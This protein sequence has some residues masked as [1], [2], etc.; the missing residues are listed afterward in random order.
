MG[1]VQTARTYLDQRRRFLAESYLAEN[2]HPT[3]RRFF[4]FFGIK[5]GDLIQKDSRAIVPE[6]E[7][8]YGDF[9][10]PP[11]EPVELQ[12]IYERHWVVNACVSKLVR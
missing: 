8:G 6:V 10:P 12:Q 2:L 9:W 5:V 3:A 7:S 4:Q 11:Y 1:I